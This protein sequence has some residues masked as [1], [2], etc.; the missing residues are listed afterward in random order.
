MAKQK[1]PVGSKKE[2]SSMDER[3]QN[4]LKDMYPP[5]ED[6]PA[7]ISIRQADALMVRVKELE[8]KL[9]GQQEAGL[10]SVSST[11]KNS[12]LLAAEPVGENRKISVPVEP[13]R[14]NAA[15]VPS[16]VT[17]P[18][19]PIIKSVRHF[20]QT[21]IRTRLTALILIMTVPLLIGITTYISSRA[22]SKIAAD[23]N[24]NLYLNNKGMATNLTTWLKF[25]AQA[26]QDMT[27]LSDI[28]SM[29]A[30]QQRPILQ[31][32]PKVY[33][34]IY[35]A[36]TTDMSGLNVARSDNA[37]PT[38]Y[39]DRVW[40]Q[41]AKT[42]TPLTYQSLIGKT[43]GK[44]ALVISM[45][46][47]NTNGGVVGTGMFAAD[48]TDLSNDILVNK[49]GQTGYIF[50]VDAN[51]MVLAH[52]NSTYTTDSLH[53]LSKYPPVAS[54]RQGKTGLIT[55]TD[56][57]GI[58]WHAYVSRL[59]NGWGIIA[60]QQESEVLAPV[61]Q[62][63]N[64]AFALILIGAGVMLALTWLTIRRTLQPIGTL[65]DTI[66]AI[67][68]GN[69]NRTVEVKSNDEIGILASTFNDMTTQLRELVISLEQRVVD[70]THDLE[71]ASE[72]GR[73]ITEKVS[74]LHDMLITAAEMIR[75]RFNLYY[76]QVYLMD[77]SGKSLTL[78]AGTGNVGQELLK[79]GH[80]LP[81]GSGSLNGRAVVEKKAVIV[82]DTTTSLTFLSNPLLPNTRS[83]MAV[84]L[85]AGGRV[86]GVLDMQSVTPGALN[87]GNLP[88]FEALAGQ[89]AIAIQNAALLAEVEQARSDVEG[90]MHRLTEQSWGDFLDAIERGQK[91]GFSFDQTNSLSMDAEAISRAPAEGTFSTPITVTGTKIGAIEL[92]HEPDR[93]WTA[94][95][96]ELIQLTANQLGQHVENLRLLAQAEKYRAEAEDAVRRLT[97]EGWDTYLQ[98]H[99]EE[100]AG[101][102]FDLNEVHPLN[103]KDNGNHHSAMV[104]SLTVQ[105]EIV[106][107]LSVNTGKESPEEANELISAVAAQLSAHIENLRLTEQTQSALNESE[108]LYKASA[109]LNTATTYDQILDILR[110]YTWL[111]HDALNISVNL[112]DRPWSSGDE[113]TWIKT[114]ASWTVLPTKTTLSQFLL[115]DFPSAGQL[116]HPDAPTLIENVTGDPKLDDNARKLYA[117]QF[118]AK[119]T[120]FIPLVVGGQWLGY[121]NAMYQQTTSFPEA[122]IR[123]LMILAGQAA[124][125]INNMRLLMMTQERV[126]REQA[127][128]EITTAVRSSTDPATIMRTA[129]SELGAILGRKTSIRM[130]TTDKAEIAA[131]SGDVS[132]LSAASSSSSAVGDKKWK[133]R[134][135]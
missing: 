56:E 1:K 100:M 48:L 35:L 102:A 127:L 78:R 81:I 83:E 6:L 17:K 97:R 120:I 123:E 10:S 57:N 66:S 80:H 94:D 9:A 72:V 22:G 108:T 131:N 44:P 55:F 105:D 111:G 116:L 30:E 110:R 42:G 64:V 76:T 53:D 121:F 115:S 126:K 5:Q 103:E 69:L 27:S 28:T 60:Q 24:N 37:A 119:S 133:K 125:A 34:Y 91:I 7:S 62:F 12:R 20:G 74:G 13:S 114:L 124:V 59:D 84:P 32:V 18:A 38:N 70:R 106:G 89:V 113:P 79:R 46:I 47:R 134:K 43:S 87:Q 45:P 112:F 52:P 104:R 86:L 21:K 135:S 98:T 92:A 31:A 50:V 14:F 85:I 29:N 75:A 71:L 118:G 23:A 63:Q 65:T 107:E 82:E 109:E 19:T 11:E 95:E 33:P 67:A 122:D 129:V 77:P 117:G 132:D 39:S 73:T 40:F 26:L 90:Q 96:T 25:N 2:K 101:F 8:E 36:S 88:A 130:A 51:N 99:G 58:R 128:R 61:R 15:T 16:A 54:L 68:A 4:R 41:K 49:I 93:T 3:F